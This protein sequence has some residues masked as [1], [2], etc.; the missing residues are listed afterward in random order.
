MGLIR[1]LAKKALSKVTG[2]AEPTKAEPAAR[3]EP[4]RP[5]AAPA[6]K[7]AAPAAKAAAPA[8]PVANAPAPAAPVA[9]AA[10]PAAPAAKADPKPAAP[11]TARA[12][13]DPEAE[14]L[15][16]RLA[17]LECGAQEVK[18]RMD[19]GEPVFVLDV[20][21]PFETA[22]GILPGARLIPLGQLPARWSEVAQANEVVVYCAAG[23]RSLQAAAFLR[24]KG[25][26]NA[27]SM[28]GGISAWMDAGGRV[29]RPG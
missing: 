9:K 17:N 1:S 7:A 13:A 12:P 10:A 25:V 11:R 22:A 18:E 19:A 5:P 28:S 4:A 6:A 2:A 29:V 24:E 26:F 3:S 16:E 14:A 21:E 20:R 27:T 8:A 23:A 15:A